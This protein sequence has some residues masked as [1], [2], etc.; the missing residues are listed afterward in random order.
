MKMK[1][2]VW[3][4]RF[5]VLDPS[6]P[7]NVKAS[8]VNNGVLVSWKEP[9]ITFFKTKK[10]VVEYMEDGWK[11]P[12][13]IV[14]PDDENSCFITKVLPSANIRVKVYTCICHKCKSSK[15]PVVS[16]VVKGIIIMMLLRA[17]KLHNSILE[18]DKELFNNR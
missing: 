10:Y 11:Y 9:F 16:T 12:G 8:S 6:P 4:L 3:L 17:V 18:N 15:S 2:K 13:I 14:V 7:Q 1:N 5:T